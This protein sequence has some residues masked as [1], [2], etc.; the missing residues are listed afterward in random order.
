MKTLF[1]GRLNYHNAL[2]IMDALHAEVVA[3][4]S[5]KGFLLVL[6][7]PPT[8]TMGNRHLPADLKVAPAQLR[9]QGIA[10]H[11]T[12]RGGSLTVHEPGQIVI[13]PL[14]R[15]PHNAVRSYVQCLE[16][17]MIQTAKHHQVDAHTHPTR[18]GVWVGHNK[19][20]ALGIRVAQKVTKHGLAFNVNNSLLTFRTIVPCGLHHTGVT[21]LQQSLNN[22]A[23]TL[24]YPKV[25]QLLTQFLLK[26]LA[27]LL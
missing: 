12:D 6:S 11:K 18:P 21:S 22:P 8:V 15:L 9:A 17:A 4:S 2:H 1:L 27:C 10:Y 19:L 25:E 7:H 26:E 23:T 14:L 5:H 24:H 20:G 3:Q 16:K 13:Y